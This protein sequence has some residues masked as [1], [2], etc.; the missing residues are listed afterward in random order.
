MFR[1]SCEPLR[2]LILLN[3]DEL[4]SDDDEARG[5]RNGDDEEEDENAL[6]DKMLKDRFL[7]RSSLD[8][9]EENFSS[10][11][12]EEQ[13]A[14]SGMFVYVSPVFLFCWLLSN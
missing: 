9:V 7:H 3:D 6:L 8:E 14:V 4:D 5:D 2:S 10:D 11:E 12:E 1:S 13:E